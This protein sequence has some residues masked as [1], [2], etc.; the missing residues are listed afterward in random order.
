[1]RC[2]VMLERCWWRSSAGAADR[3]STKA[4]CAIVSREQDDQPA[5]FE[6]APGMRGR[7][8]LGAVVFSL[9]LGCGEPVPLRTLTSADVS[10]IPPGNA[11]GTE[12]SGTYLLV[13]SSLTGCR[14][15]VGRCDFRVGTGATLTVLQQDG[16]LTVTDSAGNSSHGGVDAIGTFVYG[17]VSSL[18]SANASGEELGIV[19]GV[20][21]M[22]NGR[23]VNRP[24]AGQ[25][26]LTGTL[27]YES[28][29]CDL[30]LAGTAEYQGP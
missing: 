30:A 19:H 6:A 25:A 7:A 13:Q 18:D 1:M 12:L 2:L 24:I 26:T 21:T 3:P 15:R 9:G 5:R 28:Y 16:A 29:D 20:F 17:G 11:T 10:D 14:C 8:I 22:S 27:G 4:G 23:P